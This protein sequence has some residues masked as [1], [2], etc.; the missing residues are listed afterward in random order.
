MKRKLNHLGEENLPQAKQAK[1]SAA[2]V[3]ADSSTDALVA[4]VQAA[5]KTTNP[6]VLGRRN[7]ETGEKRNIRG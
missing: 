5:S 6:P 7:L 3:S 4:A 1:I 2:A